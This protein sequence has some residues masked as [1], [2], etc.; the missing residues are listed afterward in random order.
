MVEDAGADA[1]AD[2]RAGAEGWLRDG[3][4]GAEAAALYARM[5]E[6]AVAAPQAVIRPLTQQPAW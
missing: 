5:G 6:E 3:G 4:E 2:A 1:R